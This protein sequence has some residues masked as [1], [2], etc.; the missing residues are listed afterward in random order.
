MPTP[1]VTGTQQTPSAGTLKAIKTLKLTG[2][3]IGM[4]GALLPPKDPKS[5]KKTRRR[6]NRRNNTRKSK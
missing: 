4:S 6:K 1:V 2:W 3:T 5:P